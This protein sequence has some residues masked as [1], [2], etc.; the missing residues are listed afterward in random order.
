M[1]QPTFARQTTTGLTEIIGDSNANTFVG[2]TDRIFYGLGG[3]DRFFSNAG[4]AS[5]FVGG[6][7]ADRYEVNTNAFVLIQDAGGSSGDVLKLSRIDF[8]KTTSF[9]GFIDNRHLI[10]MDFIGDP[11]NVTPANSQIVIVIDYKTASSGIEQVQ[12]GSGTFSRAQIDSLLPQTANFLGNISSSSVNIPNFSGSLNSAVS[13]V[14][15]RA[16]ALEAPTFPNLRADSFTLDDQT[17]EAGQSVR[18]DWTTRNVGDGA[19]AVTRSAVYISTDANI[20]TADTRLAIESGTSALNPGSSVAENAT[21]TAPAGLAPGTYF[22][23]ALADSTNLVDE[24]DEGDNVSNL[25]QVI[26]AAAKANLIDESITASDVDIGAGDGLRVEVTVRNTGTAVAP[27][28]GGIDII[29]SNDAVITASDPVIGTI[30]A[31]GGLNPGQAATFVQVINSAA[32]RQVGDFFIAAEVDPNDLVDEQSEIDNFSA[33]DPISIAPGQSNFTLQT[34]ELLQ[35]IWHPGDTIASRFTGLQTGGDGPATTVVGFYLSE[36]ATV[37]TDDILLGQSPLFSIQANGQSAQRH[38]I[39]VSAEIA[40]GD[41]FLQHIID[42]FN[43]IAERDEGDNKGDLVQITVLSGVNRVGQASDDA[44]GGS[45][46]ADI[47]DGAGGDDILIGFGGDDFLIGGDGR[48]G[49]V[50]LEDGGASGVAVDLSAGT[51]RDTHGDNDTLVSIEDITGAHLADLIIGNSAANQLVGK[52]G[53]DVLEAVGGGDAL[54]GN[55]GDDRLIAGSGG[56]TLLGGSGAADVVDYLQAAAG[57]IFDLTSGSG[58]VGVLALDTLTGIEDVIGTGFSDTV[59]GND[60][61]NFIIAKSGDDTLFGEAGDDEIHGNSGDDVISGGLG[62]DLLVGGSGIDTLDFGARAGIALTF[63][64]GVTVDL[65]RDSPA[66]GL[67]S[68][69]TF[70]GFEDLAGTPGR[71]VF[72]GDDVANVLTGGDGNDVLVGRGGDDELI[73]G[74]GVDRLNGDAGADIMRGGAGNDIYLVADVSDVVI[75][76][77][78]EGIDRINTLVDYTN[79][80]NVESLVGKFARVGLT[81]TGSDARETIVG[82]NKINSGDDISGNG[83]DDR[84]VGLVG[85]DAIDGGAGADALFGNSGDDVLNG[86]AGDDNIIGSFGLDRMIGGVGRD[87]LRGGANADTFVHGTGDGSD[88][89][90]E[91]IPIILVHSL[92]L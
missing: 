53:D 6:S 26:I 76:N 70:R 89:I 9:A 81:L 75:E 31:T 35:V 72:L 18:A 27:T 3:N 20:T 1:G 28:I 17:W 34:E 40:P 16:A 74:A 49:V 59:I 44:M 63:L 79:P 5:W 60:E 83:G 78:G 21:F 43:A 42:P 58:Q 11:N 55:S 12:L 82:A 68:T 46:A 56:D 71:D 38:A 10:A 54:F 62:N 48:D 24:S 88:V 22:V 69:D 57:G 64:S 66:D 90:L 80:D 45:A 50:Y 86:G 91:Q 37:T 52:S 51:G 8:N 33:A 29:R 4:Q 77:A 41:Y 84:L 2:T 47:L 73:G 19:A 92:Q 23:G 67:G 61:A 65:N 25:Q 32:T 13:A 7:G 36:D 39:T 87:V 85:N 14:A 30:A 15:Q